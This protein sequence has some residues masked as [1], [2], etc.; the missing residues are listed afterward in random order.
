M[1]YDYQKFVP[2][3]PRRVKCCMRKSFGYLR[4]IEQ[5]MIL[6]LAMEPLRRA[7]RQ[8]NP[9]ANF[10]TKPDPLMEESGEAF[11]TFLIHE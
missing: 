10:S 5:I 11:Q 9:C 6:M 1:C 2:D 8:L 7:F 3:E 4:V